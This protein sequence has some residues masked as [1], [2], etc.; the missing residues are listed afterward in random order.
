MVK[1]AAPL[2]SMEA[3]GSLGG[4]LVFSKWKGRAYAR[5]L[6]KPSNPQTPMQV[7]IRSMLAFLAQSWKPLKDVIEGSWKELSKA[8]NVSPFNAY[9][10]YNMKSWREGMGVTQ[11]CP[12]AYESEPDVCAC[13]ATGLIRHTEISISK[14]IGITPWG[15]AIYRDIID[16]G[17][18]TWANCIKVLECPEA[19]TVLYMDGPL[20]AGTYYYTALKIYE[21]G[22]LGLAPATEWAEATVT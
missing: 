18:G 10:A 15:F 6:V 11:I 4:A 12:P 2:M 17:H 5:S 9:V 7:G 3:S 8:A 22:L 19:G 20:T 16:S 21:D 13:N 1:V 14:S